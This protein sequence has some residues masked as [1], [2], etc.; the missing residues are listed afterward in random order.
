MANVVE[1]ASAGDGFAI[2]KSDTTVFCAIALYVGTTGDV[3]LVTSR[4]TTLTF[5]GVPAGTVLPIRC[6][7]VLAATTASNI[8]GLIY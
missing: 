2:T 5:I 3:A 4:D 6:K 7:K 1:A 8:L